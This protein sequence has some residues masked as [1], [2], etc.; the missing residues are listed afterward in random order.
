MAARKPTHLLKVFDKDNDK[1]GIIG[2]GWENADGSVSVVV[3]PG[4]SVIY[5]D[6]FVYTLFPNDYKDD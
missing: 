4:C 1:R 2:A 5:K 3:N 6:S